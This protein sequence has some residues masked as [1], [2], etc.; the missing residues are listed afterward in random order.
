MT[1]KPIDTTRPEFVSWGTVNFLASEVQDR[2][3]DQ[4]DRSS[5]VNHLV[6]DF[7]GGLALSSRMYTLEEMLKEGVYSENEGII[8]HIPGVM[9]LGYRMA[10][11]TTLVSA[12]FSGYRAANKRIHSLD[13]NGRFI[14][15]TGPYLVKD[16]STSDPALIVPSTN[17][18]ISD[19]VG[20][21]TAGYFNSTRYFAI[22]AQDGTTDSIKGT[23]DP[24][25]NDI[26]WA[27]IFG[28]TSGDSCWGMHYISALGI[29]VLYGKFGGVKS[30]AYLQAADP[31]LT[32][33][34]PFNLSTS[35][36]PTATT[37]ATNQ[38]FATVGANNTGIGSIAWSNP[39]NINSGLDGSFATVSLTD[40][41]ATGE[42]SNYLYADTFGFALASTDLVVGVECMVFAKSSTP[43]S[44]N[45]NDMNYYSVRLFNDSATLFGADQLLGTK[46]DITPVT[47]VVQA[48]VFGG[49]TSMW[50]T[51]LTPTIVNDADFG[52][53]IAF[54]KN[55][56]TGGSATV[57]VDAIAMTIW[58]QR[59]LTLQSTTKSVGNYTQRTAA[60]AYAV[61]LSN[62][63]ASDDADATI[64][65]QTGAG[66]DDENAQIWTYGYG[67]ALPSNAI[68]SGIVA[69]IER[70]ESN[71]AANA[72]DTTVQLMQA[73]TAVGD[74]NS[75]TTEYGTSDAVVSY[76]SVTNVW[77]TTWTAAQV[78]NPGFGL[79]FRSNLDS[80]AITIDHIAITIYWYMPSSILNLPLG[81]FMQ[82][83][84]A[85][86]YRL[87]IIAP[88]ADELTTI[89]GRRRLY[90]LDLSTTTV[91]V[92]T[93]TQV[94]TGMNDV[95]DVWAH[96]GGFMVIGD[97]D[98]NAGAVLK[99]IDSSG[100]V[101]S[102]RMPLAHN[103]QGTASNFVGY[104]GFDLG[105][106]NLIECT[107]PNPDAQWW[108]EYNGTFHPEYA[109]DSLASATW[110]TAD[111]PLA[112]GVRHI[113]AQR[114]IYRFRAVSTTSL[115]YLRAFVPRDM[116]H[117]PFTT[118]TTQLRGVGSF[119]LKGVKFLLGSGE[120]ENTL[121]F[122]KYL[123]DQISVSSAGGTFGSI[124]LDIETGVDGTA[125]DTTFGTPTITT[126]TLTT[127]F[128]EYNVPTN[129][130]AARA[131]MFKFTLTN[132]SAT[133]VYTPNGLP[134][135]MGGVSYSPALSTWY[136]YPAIDDA[137]VA[138]YSSWGN[139][140][141]SL[142]TLA[143]TK[144][145]QTFKWGNISKSAVLVGWDGTWVVP[146]QGT[147]VTRPK[148]RP[149]LIFEEQRGTV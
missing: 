3:Q 22:G 130:E 72:D 60:S 23:T 133:N 111:A 13:W 141:A 110:L 129:G 136:V 41:G 134:W 90:F 73:F 10:G 81:G 95:R 78:N 61:N 138:K 108:L 124:K 149:V 91:G 116:F 146:T 79:I 2:A 31:L 131:A 47:D 70:A 63:T 96:Q 38:T 8:T 64:T 39:T 6:S 37:Y 121:N 75:L 125:V 104:Q 92:A 71:A 56:T 127:P 103:G 106:G 114:F 32:T 112:W 27:S 119:Y 35:V 50:N 83:T 1:T 9:A 126:G 46:P 120:N 49:Q 102:Y 99:H 5:K 54:E 43:G 142:K 147:M 52:V 66:A 74:N 68:I 101:R 12:D 48:S 93:L 123:N 87:A 4:A 69:T 44:G 33:P 143:A 137:F 17:D 62:I 21:I 26:T 58:Y 67:F 80:N 82:P 85:N 34:T 28:Y 89:T 14:A 132:A 98:E 140:V 94:Q 139:F 18:N 148:S 105:T 88:D 11:A 86:S 45:L 53:G 51:A 144:R 25:A 122:V 42:V 65:W 97:R 84:P 100:T 107:S 15:V 20:A 145:V 113:S 76:G 117:D 24:L 55:G 16:T 135:Y 40:D 118:N 57:S 128:A 19:N 7:S 77:G 59:G 30:L 29:T 109:Y 115:G 36:S